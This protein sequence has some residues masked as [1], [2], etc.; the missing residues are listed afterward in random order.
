MDKSEFVDLM[1]PYI[2]I[3]IDPMML[4]GNKVNVLF[5]AVLGKFRTSL[6]ATFT[7]EEIASMTRQQALHK[8]KLLLAPVLQ[9]LLEKL[10][11]DIL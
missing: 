3:D 6:D 11:A 5:K 1:S 10:D 8:R 4:T 9:G 7:E 2:Q